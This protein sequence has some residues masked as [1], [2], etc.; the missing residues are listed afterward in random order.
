M[1][2]GAAEATGNVAYERDSDQ[3]IR[4]VGAIASV[5]SVMGKR[6]WQRQRGA[7]ASAMRDRAMAAAFHAAELQLPE[8][9]LAFVVAR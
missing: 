9:W 2:T 7:R 6:R 3:A 4:G 1:A 8:S 5:D